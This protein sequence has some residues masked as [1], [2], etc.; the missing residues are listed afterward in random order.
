MEL[1]PTQQMTTAMLKAMAH[2]LRR[3]IL[4]V[5][6][7]RE[8]VRAAD[9]A[10]ELGE[11]ANKISFHLRVLADAGLLVEAPEHARDRRDRV[12][13]GRRG[14][15]EIGAKGSP[16]DDPVLADA[17]IAAYVDEHNDIM[18]RVLSRM[19]AYLAGVDVDPGSSFMRNRVK[20]TPERFDALLD[21]LAAAILE[22]QAATADDDPDARVYDIDILAADDGR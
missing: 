8:F 9:L 14:A 19:P 6:P 18:R 13:T 11:P 1:P 21:T 5:F 15:L 16:V 10:E 7:R 4:A 12:W 17:V 2:P 20:L 22:A 3:R